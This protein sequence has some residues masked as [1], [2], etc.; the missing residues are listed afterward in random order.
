MKPFLAPQ[1]PVRSLEPTLKCHLMIIIIEKTRKV[2]WHIVLTRYSCHTVAE[3]NLLC[4]P[5]MLITWWYLKPATISL[6]TCRHT[7]FHQIFDWLALHEFINWLCGSSF[8]YDHSYPSISYTHFILFSFF[9]AHLE[10]MV[11]LLVYCS[12]LLWTEKNNLI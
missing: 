1:G 5:F 3:L 10:W 12:T 7:K 9:S 4:T 8:L 2:D 6:F 11:G